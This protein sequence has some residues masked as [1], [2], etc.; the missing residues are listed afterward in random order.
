MA[1]SHG[2]KPTS[3]KKLQLLSSENP[4]IRKSKLAGHYR[5]RA[6]KAKSSAQLKERLP[7]LLIEPQQLLAPQTLFPFQPQ[8]L[9]LEIGFGGGEYLL[10]QSHAHPEIGFIGCEPYIN[11]MAKFLTQLPEK[12]NNIRLY[13]GSGLDLLPYFKP[14]SLHKLVLLYPDPWPKRRHAKHRFIQ[15]ET[16]N[17]L[18]HIMS[19]K[20]QVLFASD[21]SQLAAWVLAHFTAYSS[22]FTW[23]K[24][25]TQ[26]P[27]KPFWSRYE[28][29][30]VQRKKIPVRLVF[31]RK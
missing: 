6:L 5:A 30:A 10:A 25:L 19:Q 17:L 26:K 11:G 27:Q 2:K 12:Q 29:K 4:A 8:A 20:A 3:R 23:Q 14:S 18:A 7:K 9:C 15:K 16:I 28:E 22:A 31:T 24:N 1:G 13:D 21:D